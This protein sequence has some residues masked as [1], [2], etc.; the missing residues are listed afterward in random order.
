M[1]AGRPAR[2]DRRGGRTR[3]AR[4][5]PHGLR[6]SPPNP[7]T[8]AYEFTAPE[9]GEAWVGLRKTG[10]HGTAEFALDAFEVTEVTTG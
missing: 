10:D 4:A 2:L 7:A 5:G 1:R 3:T 6:R 9:E 8:L